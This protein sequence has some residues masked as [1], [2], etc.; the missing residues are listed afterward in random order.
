MI[1]GFPFFCVRTIDSWVQFWPCPGVLTNQ[2]R[3]LVFFCRKNTNDWG[4]SEPETSSTVDSGLGWPPEKRHVTTHN[5]AIFMNFPRCLSFKCTNCS[6]SEQGRL[7]SCSYANAGYGAVSQRLSAAF[8]EGFTGTP[9]AMN[10][11][12][13]TRL[14][15]YCSGFLNKGYSQMSILNH[16]FFGYPQYMETPI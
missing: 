8:A 5:S 15:A 14:M 1:V 11:P 2:A 6:R 12:N 9:N 13:Q 10:H 3:F 7:G 4:I 16:P